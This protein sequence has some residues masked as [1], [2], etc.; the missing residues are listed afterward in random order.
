MANVLPT[1]V[2]AHCNK[3]D[4]RTQ[5]TTPAMLVVLQQKSKKKSVRS[6][7]SGKI[8]KQSTLILWKPEFL[9]QHTVT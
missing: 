6:D 7:F 9:I 1:K 2:D 3:L 5:W 8:P 4:S